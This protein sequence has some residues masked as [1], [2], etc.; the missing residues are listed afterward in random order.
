MNV[1]VLSRE[2]AMTLAMQIL[3]IGGL[4]EDRGLSKDA[5]HPVLKGPMP[6][7]TRSVD[8]LGDRFVVYRD[9]ESLSI[10]VDPL[11]DLYSI[12][13]I[14]DALDL[15]NDILYELD[16]KMPNVIAKNTHIGEARDL[17]YGA[18]TEIREILKNKFPGAAAE[19]L[20]KKFHL[21]EA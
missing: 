19:E 21:N 7:D 17:L 15:L 9:G 12:G 5:G 13:Q 18:W 14:E 11:R 1:T 8:D 16:D 20:I 10:T 4:Y 2:A 6:D 3:E